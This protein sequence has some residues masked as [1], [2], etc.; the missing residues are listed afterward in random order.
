MAAARMDNAKDLVLDADI[1]SFRHGTSKLHKLSFNHTGSPECAAITHRAKELRRDDLRRMAFLASAECKYSNQLLQ[2]IPNE[3]LRFTSRE[4]RS[5][6]QIKFGVPQ[7]RW[8]PIAG[9]SITNHA[10]NT[11]LQVDVYN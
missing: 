8:L 1:K 2:G 3:A 6:V 4:F 7:S 10:K 11:P 5:A 9:Q